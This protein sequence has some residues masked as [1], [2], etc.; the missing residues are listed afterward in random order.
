VLGE[1][2]ELDTSGLA[3][4][5]RIEVVAI[6]NDGVL[7]GPP[8][9]L[10]FRL[11]ESSMDIALVAIDSSEGTKPGS[12]LSAVVEA[13]NEG[14]ERFEPEFEWRVN[15]VPVGTDETLETDRFKPGDVIVVRVRLESSNGRTRPTTSAPVMLSRGVPPVIDSKPTTGIEGGLFRYTVRASSP[16]PAAALEFELLEGPEGMAIDAKTG[17]VTW[18]PTTDQVGRFPIEIVVRDQWGSGVAQSFEIVS[19]AAG[20]APASPR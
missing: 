14:S 3:Q 1:G 16:E 17:A 2:R 20:M 15:D 4:G 10:G 7:D 6:A 8:E 18:R 5:T 13:T 9:V 19:E 12:T 11:A